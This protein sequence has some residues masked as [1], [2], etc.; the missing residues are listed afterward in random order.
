MNKQ[1]FRKLLNKYLSG[2]A[3]P[4]E[5][6]MLFDWYDASKNDSFVPDEE[7][8]TEEQQE[9][10][11]DIRSRINTGDD[12]NKRQQLFFIFKIAA[13]IILM[14]SILGAWYVIFKIN[15]T[16]KDG[17]Q[18]IVITAKGQRKNFALPDGTMVWLNSDSRLSFPIQFNKNQ[19]LVTLAGEAY[20]EVRHNAK[21]PF[22]VHTNKIDIQDIG[23]VFDVKAYPLENKVETSL[24]KGAVQVSVL[25]GDKKV[26]IL[27]PQQKFVLIKITPNNNAASHD[28][29]FVNRITTDPRLQVA[30][31]TEWRK[32]FLSFDNESFSDLAIELGRWYNVKVIFQNPA[33][34]NYRFTGTLNDAGFDTVMEALMLSEHFNYRK[35]ADHTVVIY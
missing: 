33:F 29:S 23:T 28:S 35:E 13:S 1:K 9:L 21:K 32:G 6:Q 8:S 20:F 7:L 11:L 10:F 16:A 24:I 12:N 14:V 17:A 18:N 27:Q 19:R 22:I 2:K 26:V 4:E 34:K 15:T 31:E 3:D 5:E 30:R 25:Q